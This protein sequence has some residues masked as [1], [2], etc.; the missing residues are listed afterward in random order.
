MLCGKVSHGTPLNNIRESFKL[1][2]S[3]TLFCSKV[4][5]PGASG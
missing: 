4:M 2:I 3:L 1:L 5:T